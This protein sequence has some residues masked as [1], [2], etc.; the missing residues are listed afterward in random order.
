M[1]I[2]KSHL[3]TQVF[4]DEMNDVLDLLYNT[5]AKKKN[6]GDRGNKIGQ[7]LILIIVET[8]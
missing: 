1:V 7:V 8:G 2:F 4:M 5:A 3:L 6:Q